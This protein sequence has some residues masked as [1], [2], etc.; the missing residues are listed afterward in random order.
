VFGQIA[1][2]L[3][4]HSVRDGLA[5]RARP[6]SLRVTFVDLATLTCASLAG[7]LAQG[8]IVEKL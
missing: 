5:S 6:A 4:N 3:S 2:L 8:D 1:T 7:N